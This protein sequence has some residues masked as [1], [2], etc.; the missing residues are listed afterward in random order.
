MEHQLTVHASTC[1]STNSMQSFLL[2]GIRNVAGMLPPA[3]AC[4][5]LPLLLLVLLLLLL[6]QQGHCLPSKCRGPGH[7]AK[8][9]QPAAALVEGLCIR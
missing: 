4:S 7:H 2:Q 3:A 9:L 6:S 1:Y 8:K 5:L